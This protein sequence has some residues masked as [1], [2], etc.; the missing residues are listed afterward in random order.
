MPQ[1]DYHPKS[2]VYPPQLD[3][4]PKGSSIQGNSKSQTRRLTTHAFCHKK[5]CQV[6][7]NKKKKKKPYPHHEHGLGCYWGKIGVGC[8]LQLSEHAALLIIIIIFF[9]VEKERKKK[10]KREYESLLAWLLNQKTSPPNKKC[11]FFR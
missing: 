7:N 10:K 4:H 2:P 6:Y 5:R 1:L 8:G 3:Y 11:H 9:F